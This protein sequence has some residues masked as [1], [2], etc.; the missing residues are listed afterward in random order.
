MIDEIKT[1][2]FPYTYSSSI[3]LNPL[4]TD[5]VII[6]DIRKPSGSGGDIW[7][8]HITLLDP[9]Q[10]FM[11]E[12]TSSTRYQYTDN[13]QYAVSRRGNIY[14]VNVDLTNYSVTYTQLQKNTEDLLYYTNDAVGYVMIGNKYILTSKDGTN[15][16]FLFEPLEETALSLVQTQNYGF[17]VT[18]YTGFK[19]FINLV[20]FGLCG[21]HILRMMEMKRDY[22]KLVA[23]KYHGEYFY[24]QDGGVLTAGQP[25][26][27]AG[28]SFI[29]WMGYPEIGTMEVEE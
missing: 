24:K 23:L 19:L 16:I 10:N 9:N 17:T 3:Y 5:R 6:Y 1:F 12:V 11:R 4:S 27:R 25:D 20:F 14:S 18:V 26:V 8:T 21:N 22:E 13:F 7:A 15:Y 28:K 29:G 2:S